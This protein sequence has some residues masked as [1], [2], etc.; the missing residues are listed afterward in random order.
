MAL[1][2]IYKGTVTS[3]LTDGTLVSEGTEATPIQPASYLDASINQESEAI[4]LA[5]RCDSGYKTLGDITIAPIGTSYTKWALAPDNNGVAGTFE[6]Y[7]ATL[8][9]SSEIG[10]SNTIFWVK[11]KATSDESPVND[12]TVD[13]RVTADI[14]AE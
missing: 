10:D 6:S 7:G 2:H 5:I 3:G 14:I 4:K 11:A 13:I 12:T 8:T 1:I 9:I